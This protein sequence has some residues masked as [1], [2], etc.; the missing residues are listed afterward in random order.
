MMERVTPPR[1]S[2]KRSDAAQ[3]HEGDAQRTNRAPSLRLKRGFELLGVDGGGRRAQSAVDVKAAPAPDDRRRAVR[4]RRAPADVGVRLRAGAAL[5]GAEER[6]LVESVDA[7]ERLEVLGEVR[8]R[9]GDRAGLV[10]LRPPSRWPARF[11]SRRCR[12]CAAGSEG[13]A[14]LDAPP[15]KKFRGARPRGDAGG[16]GARAAGGTRGR[17]AVRRRVEVPGNPAERAGDGIAAKRDGRRRTS[18]KDV[19]CRARR[20]VTRARAP[21]RARACGATS[22]SVSRRASV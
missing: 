6:G 8:L 16:P 3:H 12:A 14:P 10:E 18:R 22:T 1:S 11:R 21:R 19:A 5:E 4:R 15:P 2:A 17:G 9:G 20:G 7:H 13:T